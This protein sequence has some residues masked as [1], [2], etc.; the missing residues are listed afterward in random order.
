MNPFDYKKF[1][2]EVGLLNGWDFSKVKARSEGVKWQF[3]NEVTKRCRKSDRLLD[4]GTGGGETL[5]SIAHACSLLVGID[6]SSG[7]IQTANHNLDNSKITNVRFIQMDAEQLDFP[8][9][10]FNIVSCRHSP[11][12]AKEVAKVLVKDGWFLTQQVSEN[13][14]CN[15][16][17]AFGRGQNTHIDGTLKN[18]YIEEL[19][20]AG[21][22]DIQSFEYDA[23][24][25]FETYEDLVFLLKLT[26]IIPNF[27][28]YNDDFEILQTFID[29]HTT[30]KGI[31]TNSKR[32]MI[33]AKKA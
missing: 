17:Q 12:H 18:K 11:F 8:K 29:N 20:A 3:Y 4:I 32:F 5:L 28:N 2:D 10:S 16:A 31:E 27:G 15:I 26:P 30:E 13:D 23:K 6:L 21:F 24:E 22:V 9:N 14:K 33:I 1:Y 7:M 19:N 25:Y